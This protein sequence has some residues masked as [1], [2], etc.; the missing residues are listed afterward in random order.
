MPDANKIQGLVSDIA[1]GADVILTALGEA[2][3]GAVV[4]ELGKLAGRALAAYQEAVGAP[5]TPDT[6]LRLLPAGTPLAPPAN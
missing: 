2:G 3:P 4:G 5:I 1:E 6:I